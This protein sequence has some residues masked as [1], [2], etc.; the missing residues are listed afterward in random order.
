MG[1]PPSFS[2]KDFPPTPCPPDAPP[3]PQVGALNCCTDTNPDGSCCPCNIVGP[4]WVDIGDP[5][6]PCWVQ[7]CPPGTVETGSGSAGGSCGT[8]GPGGPGSPGGPLGGPPGLPMPKIGTT[9]GGGA[10]C[11]G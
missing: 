3:C 11:S 4:I 8:G 2:F 9:C 7:E 5:C 10:P 1:Y 6:H